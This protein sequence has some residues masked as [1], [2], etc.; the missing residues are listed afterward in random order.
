MEKSQWSSALSISKKARDKSIYNFVQWRHL[1]TSGN[2][3]TFYD[4]LVFLKNN[5]AISLDN[6][7]CK[8]TPQSVSA[9]I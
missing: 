1:L 8:S 9:Q 5:S 4:Y 2:Q 6:L 3:A 7:I